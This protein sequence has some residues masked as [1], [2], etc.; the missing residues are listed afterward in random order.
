[1]EDFYRFTNSSEEEMRKQLRPKAEEEVRTDLVLEA[2][3]KAEGIEATEVEID[4]EMKRLGE[5]Y[6]QEPEKIKQFLIARG[7]LE[8]YRQNIIVDKTIEFL[9][10]H[11]S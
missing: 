7:E 1:M 6:Q 3:G 9:L 5:R 8:F 11:N 4:E 10:E 2:I